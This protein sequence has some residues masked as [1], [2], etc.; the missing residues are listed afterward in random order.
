MLAFKEKIIGYLLT[1]L[2]KGQHSAKEKIMI[3]EVLERDLIS[4]KHNANLFNKLYYYL[5]EEDENVAIQ[6]SKAIDQLIKQINEGAQ[7][8]PTAVPLD[9]KQHYLKLF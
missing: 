4:S 7:V 5:L 9:T 2:N 1:S 3:L 6:A 8:T